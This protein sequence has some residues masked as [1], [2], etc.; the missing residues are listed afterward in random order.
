M[1]DQ[2]DT[3][4]LGGITFDA[5]STPDLIPGG[6]RQWTVVHKLPGGA[7]VIDTLGR[8]DMDIAWRGTFFSSDAMNQALA[9]DS[10]RIAGRV[11]PLS[12]AGSS[13]PVVIGTFLY[14]VRRYP[15]WVEYTISCIPVQRAPGTTAADSS[16]GVDNSLSS[17]ASQG[18]D[19]SSGDGVWGS[20]PPTTEGGTVGAPTTSPF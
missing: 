2:L 19:V 15:M 8:D 10:L 4:S 7:R 14:S 12:Y 6:G 17:D 20:P 3:L 5:F 9:L 18:S 13:R 11:L 16:S 1:P